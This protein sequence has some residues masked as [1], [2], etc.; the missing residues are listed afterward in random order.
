MGSD[1]GGR[2]IHAQGS[3][4]FVGTSVVGN[5]VGGAIR[6]VNTYD[7]CM[8]ASGFQ[9]ADNQI[10]SDDPR[11]RQA[12]DLGTQF[13]ACVITIRSKPVYAP[14]VPRMLDPETGR[15]SAEQMAD[16][17]TP[18]AAEGQLV[19]QLEVE[20]RPCTDHFADALG[21]LMPALGPII[22]NMRSD[23]DAL[24]AQL[25]GSQ[26]TW[27]QAARRAQQLRDVYMAQIAAANTT[28]R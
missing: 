5:D 14:I 15:A 26:I 28:T 19:A 23:G 20:K 24:Y 25:A 9:K 12:K 11:V 1:P 13:N 8:E 6:E 16:T 27:G 3:P 2:V 10:R 18:T 7:A 4:Q 22:A 21:Q 17:R